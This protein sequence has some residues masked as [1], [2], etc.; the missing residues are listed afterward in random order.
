MNAPD[1][2]RLSASASSTPVSWFVIA[3][4]LAAMLVVLIRTAWMS[5]D[6]YITMR[7]VDNFVNGFGLRWNVVER[8][9]AFTHPAWLMLITPFYA[10][11]REAFLP[12]L[13][14]RLA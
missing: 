5:D 6:A 2:N 4:G 1:A 10:V 8:V 14:C 7:T 9:Q 12:V 11:T 3:G 13:G